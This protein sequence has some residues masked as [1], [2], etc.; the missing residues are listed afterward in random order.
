M[1]HRERGAN[2]EWV[3]S[4]VVAVH[5][6]VAIDTE[7]FASDRIL[8]VEDNATAATVTGSTLLEI[9]AER[10]QERSH[11]GHGWRLGEQHLDVWNLRRRLIRQ[12]GNLDSR[13][14]RVTAERGKTELATTLASGEIAH[15]VAQHD[16]LS[17]TVKHSTAV[18]TLQANTLNYLLFIF[19]VP[20]IA[21]NS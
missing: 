10:K 14:R 1:R 16:V 6:V 21:T 2:Q 8:P 17:I 18:I 12:H 5:F 9:D 15:V 4:V 20:I 11:R 13:A 7:R 19:D 3:V